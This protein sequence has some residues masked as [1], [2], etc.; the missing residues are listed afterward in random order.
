MYCFE[1][2]EEVASLDSDQGGLANGGRP[3]LAEVRWLGRLPTE[4]YLQV[5][6]WSDT[7]SWS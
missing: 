6:A 4:V 5:Q 7:V 1:E 2:K 3:L